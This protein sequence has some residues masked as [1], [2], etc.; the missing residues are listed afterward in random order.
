MHGL[1]QLDE[2]QHVFPKLELKSRACA[3]LQLLEE[4]VRVFALNNAALRALPVRPL[5]HGL[6]AL[7][8]LLPPELTIS[9]F[10]IAFALVMV[11]ATPRFLGWAQR[12]EARLGLAGAG[13]AGSSDLGGAAPEVEG[14]PCQGE[15]CQGEL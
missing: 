7:F 3:A 11:W 2:Q 10:A 9:L 12:F 1:Q 4:H 13:P 5:R 15:H 8:K 6:R 14:V